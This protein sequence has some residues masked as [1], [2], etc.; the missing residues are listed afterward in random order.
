MSRCPHCG[1]DLAPSEGRS[2]LGC[3]E[4]TLRSVADRAV[5]ALESAPHPLA[6]WDIKRLIDQDGRGEVNEGTLKV[7]LAGDPRT[8]WAGPGVYGLYRHGL[9]PGIRDLGRVG[10]T[11]VY[12]AQ[13][14][15]DLPVLAFTMRAMGYRFH[16]GSLRGA[17]RRASSLGL[18]DQLGASWWTPVSRSPAADRAAGRCLGLRRGKALEAVLN[19]AEGH[20]ARAA[21]ERRRRL[22][23]T[24]ARSD[25]EGR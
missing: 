8:C 15:L 7:Q 19:R 16:E 23:G 14:P 13:E 20:V 9:L 24:T 1:A 18:L 5:R 22:G 17:M 2:C 10:A 3:S 12:L 4:R 21:E 25:A 11:I 6:H